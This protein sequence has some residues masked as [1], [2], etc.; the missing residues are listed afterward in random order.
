MVPASVNNWWTLCQ[1]L[2]SCQTAKV[3]VWFALEHIRISTQHLQKEN[4]KKD[5][6]KWLLL[7]DKGSKKEL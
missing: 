6:K 2:F 5:Y 3:R 4:D 1:A 7:S